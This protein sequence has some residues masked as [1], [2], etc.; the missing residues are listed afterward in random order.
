M[1]DVT[2]LLDSPEVTK[3]ASRG[4]AA[5]VDA[6]VTNLSGKAIDKCKAALGDNEDAV[7][8]AGLEMGQL[9]PTIC[10]NLK[11][12][13]DKLAAN[14]KFADFDDEYVASLA[15]AGIKAYRMDLTMLDNV[16]DAATAAVLG[17]TV[18]YAERLDDEDRARLEKIVAGCVVGAIPD[19][20][21]CFEESS[22][23][24]S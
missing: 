22:K 3:S 9:W 18:T 16:F 11:E 15:H 23:K 10:G 7:F 8:Q 24:K 4:Y 20:Y 14:L 21:A 12:R 19:P 1:E 17:G 13:Y 5:Y 6:V 2:E